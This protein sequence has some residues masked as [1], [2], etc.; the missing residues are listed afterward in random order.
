MAKFIERF[1]EHFRYAVPKD[2]GEYY[3]AGFRDGI[4]FANKESIRFFRFLRNTTKKQMKEVNLQLRK[5]SI[6]KKE[7]KQ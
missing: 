6:E 3:E 5:I 4:K 2:A 1:L 7:E